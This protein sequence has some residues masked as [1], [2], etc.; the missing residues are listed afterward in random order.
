MLGTW[1]WPPTSDLHLRRRRQADGRGVDAA[2]PCYGAGIHE[3]LDWA[4]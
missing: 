3:M 2:V 1:R 4:L